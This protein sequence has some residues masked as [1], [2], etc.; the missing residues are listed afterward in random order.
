MKRFSLN[1]R[2]GH[3]YEDPAGMWVLHSEAKNA[4]DDA[5]RAAAHPELPTR[6]LPVPGPLGPGVD[7]D[8]IHRTSR[9]TA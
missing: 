3:M 8:A 5:R 4:V 6:H 7:I 2:F 9:T 1:A